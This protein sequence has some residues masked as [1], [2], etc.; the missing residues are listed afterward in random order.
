MVGV[1]QHRLWFSL[2]SAV[3]PTTLTDS[4]LS[5]LREKACIYK[6]ERCPLSSMYS[7]PTSSAAQTLVIMDQFHLTERQRHQLE[8]RCRSGRKRSESRDYQTQ[9]SGGHR[10][11]RPISEIRPGLQHPSGGLTGKETLFRHP[12]RHIRTL[13]LPSQSLAAIFRTAAKPL[14][15]DRKTQPWNS[16]L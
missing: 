10:G 1:C 16:S 2:N 8:D 5:L 15:E 13:Y 12:R 7:I 6:I 3:S 4:W 9:D 14:K 11:M